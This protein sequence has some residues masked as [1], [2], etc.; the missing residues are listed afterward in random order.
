[1][2]GATDDNRARRQLSNIR[3][4]GQPLPFLPSNKP[5]KYLGLQLTLTL[6]WHF[7]ID[8]VLDNLRECSRRLCGSF[9][10]E[11]QC[12]RVL[13]QCILPKITYS[14]PVAPYTIADIQRIDKEVAKLV[15]KA[16]RLPPGLPNA[17]IHEDVDKM[18]IGIPSLMVD[19]AYLNAK[20]LLTSLEDPGS[21]GA[22]TRAL[23]SDQLKYMGQVHP[24]QQPNLAKFCMNVRQLSLLHRCDLHLLSNGQPMRLD[25]ND[26][27]QHAA[28]ATYDP[29]GFGTAQKLPPRILAPLWELD[30]ERLSDLLA[31]GHREPTLVS[32]ADL[33][34]QFGKNVKRRHMLA[35]TRLTLVLCSA[36]PV[37]R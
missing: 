23:L 24:E 2:Q 14:F 31:S 7:Q 4:C 8:A 27:L 26:L 17:F 5:Y 6:D 18:G 33:Q 35:M 30:I 21:L 25:G 3:I 22:I 20:S 1:M 15:R 16:I 29:L 37:R 28:A 12:L 19:Y 11:K 10:S 13:K 34:R 9:A 36:K 32:T